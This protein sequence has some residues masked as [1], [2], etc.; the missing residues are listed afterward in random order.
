ML[1]D[2]HCHIFDEVFQADFPSLLERMKDM[3]L[4]IVGFDPKTNQQALSLATDLK[5]ISSVGVHP[6]EVDNVPFSY[7]EEMV[8]LLSNKTIKAIGECGLDYHYVT[9]NKEKQ[10]A[11][12]KKQIELSIEYDLPLII[13]ERDSVNDCYEMLK[14]Y[15]GKIH[16]VMHC[17]SGSIEM[18]RKFVDLGLFLGLGG[19]VTYKNSISPKEVAKEIPLEKIVIETDSPFLPPVPFRGKRNEPDYVKYTCQTI[20]MLRGISYEEVMEKT[21]ENGHRL[22]RM[23]AK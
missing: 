17:F 21:R 22:F 23:E 3:E 11:Y 6:E 2:T 1:F 12:F 13:H 4:M 9:D 20:S 10:K 8:K 14:P 19:P 15:K 5:Q 18:A 7:F 16:G